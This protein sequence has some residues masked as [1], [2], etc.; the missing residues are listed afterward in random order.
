MMMSDIDNSI[1]SY[2]VKIR[3]LGNEI[4]CI[5]LST[6]NDSN[7]W[8]AISLITVFS[9]L[10]VLGAYGEKLIQLYHYLVQ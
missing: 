3:I 10:T 4:F 7:R 6:T 2:E 8:I 9:L 1:K 5:T